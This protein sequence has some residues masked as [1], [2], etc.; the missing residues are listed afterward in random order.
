QLADLGPQSGDLLVTVIGRPALEGGLSAGQEVIAP[1]G[2]G[3]GRDAQFAGE[4]FQALAAEEAEDGGGLARGRGAAAVAGV[5]GGGEGVGQGW[6][7]L[8][9]TQMMAQSDVQ[10]N[11]GAEEW[12]VP[13]G[14]KGQGGDRPTVPPPRAKG[15][16]D[17]TEGRFSD[18][19]AGFASPASKAWGVA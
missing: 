7:L 6:G 13:R 19:G 9:W 8:G 15:M 16:P 2:E 10:R 14:G 11:A 1:T 3:G 17:G 18:R 12:G 5:R 4:Q